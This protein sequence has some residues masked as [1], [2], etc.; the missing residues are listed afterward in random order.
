MPIVKLFS[1]KK[2]DT[3]CPLC[4][5]RHK[6]NGQMAAAVTTNG[7]YRGPEKS[8]EISLAIST[9]PR[10]AWLDHRQHGLSRLVTKSYRRYN[11]HKAVLSIG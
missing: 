8:P 11:K 10:F 2:H 5:G 3:Y 9:L 1:C 6:Q 7:S 4:S